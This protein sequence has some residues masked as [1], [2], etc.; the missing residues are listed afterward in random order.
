MRTN[1]ILSKE[2]R[3]FLTSKNPNRDC[4]IDYVRLHI[5]DGTKSVALCFRGNLATLYYR[6]HQLLRIRCSRTAII[7]EFDFRHSR[8]TKNYKQILGKLKSLN[9]R[10]S[11]FSDEPNRQAQKYVRFDLTGENAV[12]REQMLEILFI[13]KSLIDDFINPDNVEYAFDMQTP[14]SKSLNLEKDRQQQL[15]STYFLNNELFY[16]D[17][18]YAEHYAEKSGLHGRFDL[19]GLRKEGDTYTLLLTELKSTIGACGGNSGIVQHEKDYIK[20]LNSE[21]VDNRKIEACEAVKLL[22]TIFARTCPHNLTMNNIMQTKIKFVFSDDAIEIGKN[23]IPQDNRIEKVYLC[24]TD[25][26]EKLY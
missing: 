25:V 24:A 16:Y 18:E 17:I 19:L 10:V 3:Q 13:F 8:F 21:F 9:V 2:L 14:R 7:G 26:T 15:Y 20:Y 5:A 4:L 11:G 6:C 23:Y 1:R 22:C 12:S